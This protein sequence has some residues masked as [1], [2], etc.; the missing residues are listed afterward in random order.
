MREGSCGLHGTFKAF[1]VNR[2]AIIKLII[3]QCL[4]PEERKDMT[5]QN[6]IYK[7]NEPF[8][9]LGMQYPD[10]YST[11]AWTASSLLRRYTEIQSK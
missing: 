3:E 7:P 1:R 2:V 6:I 10:H 8:V 9:F 5:L 4:T 11:I